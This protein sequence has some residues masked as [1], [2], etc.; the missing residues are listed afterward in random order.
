[1]Q[2]WEEV[3][4]ASSS[5]TVKKILTKFWGLDQWRRRRITYQQLSF[6]TLVMS[7]T[8]VRATIISSLNLTILPHVSADDGN[9]DLVKIPGFW[10][11]SDFFGRLWLP[12][13]WKFFSSRRSLTERSWGQQSWG[14]IRSSS[15]S[16]SCFLRVWLLLLLLLQLLQTQHMRAGLRGNRGNQQYKW[17][18][19][20]L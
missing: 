13:D 19:W 7:E 11:F 15:S 4:C 3:F 12:A 1:M 18:C 10:D 5:K 17:L 2:D 16:A 14:S 20:H 8:R 9:V 6:L